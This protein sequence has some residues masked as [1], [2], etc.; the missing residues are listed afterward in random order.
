MSTRHPRL[1]PAL[2][3]VAGHPAVVA[4]VVALLTGLS[5][6]ALATNGVPLNNAVDVWFVQGDPQ[7][8]AYHGFQREFGNDEVLVGM[9]HHPEGILD[10]T[11]LR[12]IWN[13]SERISGIQGVHHVTGLPTVEHM[14][15][16]AAGLEVTRLMTG[17]PE[18]ESDVR[19]VVRRLESDPLVKKQLLSE[20]RTTTVLLA[21]MEPMDDIDRHRHRII[22]QVDAAARAILGG[23]EGGGGQR[24]YMAGIGVVYDALNQASSQDAG[25]FMSLA[26]ILVLLSAGSIFRRIGPLVLTMATVILSVVVALGVFAAAGREMN[27]VTMLLPT[28]VL[29]IGILDSVHMVVHLSHD[30]G[31]SGPPE[32]LEAR[33]DLV[34]RSLADVVWPCL[35]TSVTTAVGFGAL[36]SARISAIKDLGLFTAVGVM[37]AWVLT[38]LLLTAFL[39]YSWLMP[40]PHVPGRRGTTDRLLGWIGGLVR[41]HPRAVIVGSALWLLAGAAGMARLRVDT[42]SIGFFPEGH[43]VRVASDGIESL[44][45][46]YTPLE[47][48][49]EGRGKGTMERPDVLAGIA[50][51]QRAMEQDRDVSRTL[52]LADVVAQLNRVMT[53]GEAAGVPD[54]ADAVAQLLVLYDSDPDNQR[55]HWATDDYS[56]GRV[57]A[58]VRMMSAKGIDAAIGRLEALARESLPEGVRVTASGYLPL[59][60]EMMTYVVQSQVTSFAIAFGLVFLLIGLL[61]GTMKITALALLP[62]LIPV[63]TTLGIMGWAGIRLDVATVT[64]AP[65]VI[66]LAVDDTIHFLYRY[67]VLRSEGLS[68]GDALQGTVERA[69][70][71]MAATSVI[72]LLGFGILVLATVKSVVYMGLLTSVAVASA[73]AGDILL[74]P[75]LLTLFPTTAA[76]SPEGDR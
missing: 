65:I 8:E 26:M 59:Y 36:V 45:G 63:F 41:R 60:V 18:S 23:A 29:I 39:P 5:L 40:K 16:T 9:V 58:F 50:R 53:D 6:W 56:L 44:W 71:A 32:D 1:E 34:A 66:G 25:V 17:P 61:F 13:L 4:G 31:R 49:V 74:L 62:N 15:A 21:R 30:L 37:V 33:R 11:S 48:V 2:R 46:F 14:E 38:V 69:G 24:W 19:R 27:M 20:D 12:K 47:F 7:L 75:A 54:R 72:L 64:I 67:E 43:P 70:R 28:L 68:R 3:A 55:S 57:T 52:S 10:Q 73:F 42:Y 22:E 51:W 35:L 76:P